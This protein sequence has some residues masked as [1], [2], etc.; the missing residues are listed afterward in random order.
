LRPTDH[1]LFELCMLNR[2]WRIERTSDGEIIAM[3]PAGGRTGQR[4]FELIGLFR[5]WVV[6]DGTGLGFDSSTGFI[7]PNGAERSPDLAWVSRARWDALSE[8][9]KEEFPP[10]CPDFVVELRSRS[11]SLNA[12]R[13]KMREYIANGARLGWLIDPIDRRVHIYRPP[14]EETRLNDPESVS[15][16]PVL[17]GFVLEPRRLWT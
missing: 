16:D 3:P 14:A 5:A 11:D 17:R 8:A 9:Q 1:E 4:N 2:D 10:L 15:G 7:L 13:E 12:L 6:T